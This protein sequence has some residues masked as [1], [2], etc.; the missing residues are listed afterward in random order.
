[1]FF[2]SPLF[3]VG[4]FCL[5]RP[6]LAFCPRWSPTHR[7]TWSST[8]ASL[9]S[10]VSVK[11][12][13]ILQDA[14]IPR[15]HPLPPEEAQKF[16]QALERGSITSVES[17]CCPSSL[18]LCVLFCSSLDEQKHKGR[19]ERDRTADCPTMGAQCRCLQFPEL[20]W[21]LDTAQM[22]LD[23]SPTLPL[24]EGMLWP[25]ANDQKI[26]LSSKRLLSAWLQKT[27]VL[28]WLWS[29]PLEQIKVFLCRGMIFAPAC[30]LDMIKAT[31]KIEE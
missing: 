18:L 20:V 5:L 10:Q 2:F 4:V 1:M 7:L 24:L 16:T 13:T 9:Q 27:Q 21:C 30:Y 8:S 6:N 25:V 26:Y 17:F 19:R 14:G 29:L 3:T 12:L 23:F 15:S 31:E 22:S 11:T 28:A